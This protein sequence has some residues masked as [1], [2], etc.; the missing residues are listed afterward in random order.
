V[1]AGQ[2]TTVAPFGE[3][4]QQGASTASGTVYLDSNGNGVQD[5]GETGLA[6]WYTYIDVNDLGY[7]V[8]GD[9]YSL[10]DANGNYSFQGLAPGSYLI[11]VYS[12]SGY[13]TTQGSE[14]WTATVNATTNSVGADFGETP[15]TGTV[16]GD[17]YNDLNAD[18]NQ[19]SGD[20]GLS[21]WQ[22]YIDLGDSGSYVSGDPITTTDSTGTYTFTGLQP[23]TYTI[24]VVDE[25]AFTTTQGSDGWTATVIAG[26]TVNGGSFGETQATGSLAGTVYYDEYR[27][28]IDE[29]YDYGISNWAVYIDLNDT[30]AYATGDPYVLTNSYGG[31]TFT[32]LAPGTYIVRAYVYAGTRW[33]ATEGADGWTDTVLANQNSF[34]GNFGEF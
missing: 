1:T 19:D 3:T 28:G 29:G 26:Q 4:L 25:S 10:T 34:A 33:I 2:A 22:V 14:G 18:S 32:G 27:N 31:Y 16:S 6:G 17:V 21:G 13:T 23:G 20:P 12:Q 30:G 5:A 9:P 7:Y 8:S 24:R 15:A 11:R